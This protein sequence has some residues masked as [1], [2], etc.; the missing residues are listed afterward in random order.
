MVSVLRMTRR[1][2]RLPSL[3]RQFPT[4]GF[5][6]LDSLPL[7]EEEREPFYS[8]TVFYPAEIGEVL[9][10]R[11]QIVGKLGYGGYSTVWLCRDLMSVPIKLDYNF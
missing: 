4:T 11:Y 8:P 1:Y 9:H 3:P 2:L 6:I 5:Q 10:V 7:V